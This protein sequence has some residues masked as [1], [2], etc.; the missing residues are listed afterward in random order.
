MNT[1]IFFCILETESSQPMETSTQEPGPSD[2]AAGGEPSG[3]P[4]GPVQ[5]NSLKCDE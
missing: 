3:E 4:A 1:K 5:A 2:S